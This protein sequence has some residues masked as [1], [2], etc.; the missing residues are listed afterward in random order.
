[1][2]HKATIRALLASAAEP[3]IADPLAPRRQLKRAAWVSRTSE[4]LARAQRQMDARCDAAVGKV[5]EAA[6]NR[7]F[8]EEQAKVCA[9]LNPLRAAAHEDRWPRHLYWGRI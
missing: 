9:F 5:S 2:K 6:F 7:L 3:K 1:M 4:A 8:D